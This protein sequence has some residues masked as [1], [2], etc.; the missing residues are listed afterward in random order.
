MAEEGYKQHDL[1][2]IAQSRIMNCYDLLGEIQLDLSMI[3][4]YKY[5]GNLSDESLQEARQLGLH[6]KRTTQDD[7]LQDID[8]YYDI[9]RKR[10]ASP[11]VLVGYFIGTIIAF[12]C[13][14]KN[15]PNMANKIAT[16]N[17]KVKSRSVS[18]CLKAVD[19]DLNKPKSIKDLLSSFE[20]S[21][22]K[23]STSLS[24]EKTDSP[25]KK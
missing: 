23:I 9:L 11:D 24:E 12:S 2:K 3:N 22:I 14:E 20:K 13:L 5:L 7:Y 10:K 25:K 21:V 8:E 18:E 1:A 15:D 16:L 6:I 19:I 4:S 17:E